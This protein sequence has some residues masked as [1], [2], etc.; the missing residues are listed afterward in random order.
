VAYDLRSIETGQGMNVWRGERM[1]IMDL[2][3]RWVHFRICDV[4]HPDPAQV[5]IDLHGDDVLSGKVVDLS[6]S[7]MQEA[8]FVVVEVEGVRQAVIVPVERILAVL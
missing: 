8:A 4:Y 3:D 7:G 1:I 5:L 6:D 2:R